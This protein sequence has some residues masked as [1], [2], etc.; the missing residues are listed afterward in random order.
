MHCLRT[1][2]PV[3]AVAAVALLIVAAPILAH[4]GTAAFDTAK[5]VTVKG[6]ITDFQYLNPHAQVYFEAPNEKGEMEKW[7]GELTAPNKLGR[8]GWSKYTLKPGD[9]VEVSGYPA[10][11]S[12]HTLWIRKLIGPDGNEL[13][14]FED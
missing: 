1:K 7:Q 11:A 2:V 4:H 14:L 12:P 8:A 3:L 9:H 6:N 13:Q 5:M 10:K